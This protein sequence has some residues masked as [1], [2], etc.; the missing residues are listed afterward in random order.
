MLQKAY[1][2]PANS[3]TRML[4]Y[5]ASALIDERSREKFI[6]IKGD[7]TNWWKNILPKNVLSPSMTSSSNEAP[8]Q[9]EILNHFSVDNYGYQVQY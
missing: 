3:V 1:I 4:F 5:G 2:V 8:R 9:A 6:L 7:D